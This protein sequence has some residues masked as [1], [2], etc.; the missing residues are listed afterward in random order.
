MLS[1][2]ILKKMSEQLE[3]PIKQPSGQPIQSTEFK[4]PSIDPYRDSE[5]SDKLFWYIKKAYMLQMS[6]EDI[7]KRFLGVGWSIDFIKDSLK[8]LSVFRQNIVI[9]IK[10]LTKIFETE[11]GSQTI[12]NDVNLEIRKGEFIAITGRSGAGKSTL[13]NLIGLL[14]QPSSGNIFVEGKDIFGFS[15]RQKVQYRLKMVSYIFQFFNLIDNYNVIENIAFPLKLQGYGHKAAMEKS[16]EIIEFLNME[17]RAYCYPKKLSGGEQQRVA[18]GR[19]LAKDS[20]IVLAD[21]P[22]AHLD[23]KNGLSVINL[24]REINLKFGKTMILVTHEKDF[25]KDAD[26]VVMLSDGKIVE[27]EV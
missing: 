5:Q 13:L 16:R 6:E 7:I 15:E 21:E 2:I 22:T 20:L 27:V 26:T 12:L 18:I 25:T 14:D 19:A 11:S 3:P 8:R 24:L 10:N 4:G 9:N 23:L 17:E 1:G